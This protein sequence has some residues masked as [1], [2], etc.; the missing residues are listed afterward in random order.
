[1]DYKDKQ[2]SSRWLGASDESCDGLVEGPV[3]IHWLYQTA[4]RS[5]ITW[6][7]KLGN[8][9]P[10]DFI[11]PHLSRRSIQVMTS[12]ENPIM[13]AL[14]LPEFRLNGTRPITGNSVPCAGT[15]LLISVMNYCLTMVVFDHSKP[16]WLK[17]SSIAVR[18][19]SL[20]CL[21]NFSCFD[22]ALDASQRVVGGLPAISP[23]HFPP[24]RCMHCLSFL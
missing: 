12:H 2:A 4:R 5:T 22:C 13:H 1:M 21:T 24:L 17:T 8:N 10:I 15:Q 16:N 6:L 20:I 14:L 7:T 3:W 23:C 19:F 11:E 18:G 9:K